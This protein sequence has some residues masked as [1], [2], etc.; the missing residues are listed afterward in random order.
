MFDGGIKMRQYKGIA[1]SPG[2]CRSKAKV[3]INEKDFEKVELGDIIVVYKSSP[4]WIIP[5]M[6]AGGMICEIGGSFSHIGILSRE[7]SKP[8]VSGISNIF[9]EIHDNDNIY[10]DGTLGEIQ[11]YE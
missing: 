2:I 11:V 10:I 6:K 7:L 4:A 9:S 1:V 5:L 8:C 3:I